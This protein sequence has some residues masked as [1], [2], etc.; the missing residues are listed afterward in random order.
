LTKFISNDKWLVSITIIG[1]AF[2]VGMTGFIVLNDKPLD[3]YMYLISSYA[4]GHG[5]NIY[6]MP[7]STYERIAQ[8]LGIV[9]KTTP[10]GYPTF[11]ALLI[12]P[13]SFLPLRLGATIWVGLSGLAALASGLILCS[14][15]VEKW[16]QRVI[17]VST[18]AFVPVITTMNAGQVN[19]FV[20]LT[21]VLSLYCLRQ[22]RNI[23]SGV[24][25]A[26]SIW[27]KPFAIAL[28][29][30]MIWRRKWKALG[31]FLLGSLIINLI[32]LA[33]FGVASTISQFTRVMSMV[34]PSGL[35]IALTVQNLNGLLGRFTTGIS[36][37][38]GSMIYLVVA[39]LI[40]V[41]TVAAIIFKPDRRNFEMEAALLIAATHLIVPLTWYHHLTMLIL[42]LAFVVVSW[43]NLKVSMA[44]VLLLLGFVLTDI[45][46]LLWK[47]LS[48]LHP[49]LSNFPVL[50]TLFL[51]GLA[52]ARVY[53]SQDSSKI[54]IGS[55]GNLN[56]EPS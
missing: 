26:I 10:Y 15:T 50:T 7:A 32:S 28:V 36:A 16:K 25:L 47:Q 6:A 4:L 42:V 33:V 13:L 43:N 3:Y 48:N 31:G 54:S 52:L 44:V 14:F 20:L 29:P 35:Y 46:G 22:D 37:P 17:L 12:Y 24:I 5:E 27:L 30:L 40:G 19:L 53:H 49:I 18:I 11:T 56:A 1:L 8:H 9:T 21:T 2:Y 38:T 34:T 23:L 41:I 55:G 51:W 39:G 45:H